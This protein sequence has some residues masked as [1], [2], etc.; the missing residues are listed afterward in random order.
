MVVGEWWLGVES[1]VPKFR[2]SYESGVDPEF[3][4]QNSELKTRNSKLT[5]NPQLESD[6]DK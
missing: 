2:E 6:N 4:E 1:S 5:R 3:S